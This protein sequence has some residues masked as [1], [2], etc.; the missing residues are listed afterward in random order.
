MY[1]RTNILVSAPKFG[2]MKSVFSAFFNMDW[3]LEQHIN[4]MDKNSVL[5]TPEA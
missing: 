5:F 4:T 1:G 3:R 2:S